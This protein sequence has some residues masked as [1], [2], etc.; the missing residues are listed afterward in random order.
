VA[1]AFDVGNG[2]T[3]VRVEIAMDGVMAH[4]DGRWQEAKGATMLVR[5]LE[6][7]PAEPTLGAILA[8]RDGG[9]LGSAEEVAARI[10]Q[11]IRD[12][13]WERIPWGRFSVTAPPGF[14]RWQTA[15]FWECDRH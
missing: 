12:A 14:G 3:D 13:G 1:D 10:N 11:A 9:V 5:R 2:L 6:A 8:R 15:T 7:T 4:I